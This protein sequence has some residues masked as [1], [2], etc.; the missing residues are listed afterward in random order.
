MNNLNI[1]SFHQDDW[2][3]TIS[4]NRYIKWDVNNWYLYKKDYFKNVN[5]IN[6]S[7]SKHKLNIISTSRIIEKLNN[8]WAII[9]YD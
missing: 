9:N 8:D 5:Y 4:L 6:P 7:K 2:E 3:I 1:E